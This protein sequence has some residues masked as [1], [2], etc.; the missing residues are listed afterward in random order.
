MSFAPLDALVS[1]VATDPSGLLDR[2]DT[3]SI[4]DG[5]TRL[6]IPAYPLALSISQGS[7]KAKP[8]AFE[9]QAPKMVEHGLPG[10]EVA[11]QVAPRA[12]GAQDVEDRVEDGT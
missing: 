1:I 9:A 8:D 3:L 7:K 2:L 11:R 12:A 4:H 10:R 6:C 5:C